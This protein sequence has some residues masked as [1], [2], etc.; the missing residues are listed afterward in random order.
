MSK[1]LTY[2]LAGFEPRLHDDTQENVLI[3]N[4]YLSSNFAEIIF[5]VRKYFG[6]TNFAVYGLN[7]YFLRTKGVPLVI[8]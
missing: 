1:N 2:T 8:N 6:L 7:E 4:R 5:Q 3:L